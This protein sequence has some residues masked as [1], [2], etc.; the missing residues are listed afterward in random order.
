MTYHYKEL[1][2]NKYS[3][4][5]L[6]CL[7]SIFIRIPFFNLAPSGK[8]S[9]TMY[10]IGSLVLQGKL[11]SWEL[12]ILSLFG[13][14]PFS[15]YPVGGVLLFAILE[16]L[17]HSI[18]LTFFV[19]ST[20]CAIIAVLLSFKVFSKFTTSTHLAIF[21][22]LIYATFPDFLLYTY[23]SGSI[24]GL[25]IALLPGFYLL[26]LRFYDRPNI[27]NFLLLIVSIVFLCLFHR[28]GI[29][30]LVWVFVL[31][32]VVV[33]Q[34]V[35]FSRILNNFEKHLY[36][37][38]KSIYIFLSVL[39]IFFMFFS[40]YL[41]NINP[42]ELKN[43]WFGVEPGFNAF[44]SVFIDLCLRIGPVIFIFFLGILQFLYLRYIGQETDK[45]SSL[46][47]LFLFILSP[48]YAESLYLTLLITLPIVIFSLQFLN[49]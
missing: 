46:N 41:I 38:K 37:F 18:I 8:D 28:T 14:Y 2:K 29:V 9:F 40:T 31:V 44:I 10:W 3:L 6:A 1:L 7:I 39:S 24:R 48:F 19:Y 13:L 21:G 25:F 17:L 35:N 32:L 15:G 36:Y 33:I 45:Y 20:L 12:N 16:F 30:L 23:L 34:K 11:G 49:K 47:F 4:L 27:Q 26:C 42:K 22:A 5:G 43:P